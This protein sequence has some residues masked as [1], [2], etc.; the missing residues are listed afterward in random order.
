[1]RF[2]PFSEQA[3]EDGGAREA[4]HGAAEEED[5]EGSPEDD[6][7]GAEDCRQAFITF[8][9]S[10]ILSRGRGPAEESKTLNHL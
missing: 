10:S 9:Q 7:E 3:T 4:L 5:G 2:L 1:M 6:E 8:L